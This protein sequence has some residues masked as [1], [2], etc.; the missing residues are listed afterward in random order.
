MS[1]GMARNQP[2]A[3]YG[4]RLSAL[5]PFLAC[6]ACW[7][8]EPKIVA[9]DA[10]WIQKIEDCKRI[11]NWRTDGLVS[12]EVAE[13]QSTATLPAFEK[14][15]VSAFRDSVACKGVTLISY[16]KLAKEA[17]TKEPRWALNAS[18]AWRW[19]GQRIVRDGTI[20]WFVI[21]SRNKTSA[22]GLDIPHD[23]ATSVCTFVN[24]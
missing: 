15:L 24:G 5:V 7:S 21:D 3:G 20:E 18:L 13:C 16:Q 9:Y 17:P 8:D 22:D 10:W 1:D 23:M 2:I 14:I 6:G 12:L 4:K 19:E 11:T